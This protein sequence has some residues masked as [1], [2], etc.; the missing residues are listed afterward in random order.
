MLSKPLF[1]FPLVFLCEFHVSLLC[2]FRKLE[3][4]S[5]LSAFA[6]YVFKF[7]RYVVKSFVISIVIFKI[8]IYL[9]T[10]FV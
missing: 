8:L 4:F 3:Y 6:L 2:P 5:Y 9:T 1:I 10:V 7:K